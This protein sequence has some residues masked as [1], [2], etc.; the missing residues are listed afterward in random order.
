MNTVGIKHLSDGESG[1]V[2]A[3]SERFPVVA[4][5]GIILLAIIVLAVAHA[6]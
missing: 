5:A 4:G 2:I 1:M 3:L 6:L